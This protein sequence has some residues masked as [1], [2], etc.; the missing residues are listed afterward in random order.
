LAPLNEKVKEGL[1]LNSQISEFEA[2]IANV[3]FEEY[4]SKSNL[5]LAKLKLAQ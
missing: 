2:Q 1:L 5:E 4:N 3:S